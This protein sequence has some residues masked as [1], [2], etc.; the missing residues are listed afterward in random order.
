VANVG[1]LNASRMSVKAWSAGWVQPAAPLGCVWSATR[2]LKAKRCR[3]VRS[4][5]PGAEKF[6]SWTSW[7]S[8]GSPFPAENP[9]SPWR[10]TSAAPRCTT[11]PT[12][13]P[14]AKSIPVIEL[15]AGSRSIAA[16]GCWGGK[17]STGCTGVSLAATAAWQAAASK[18]GMAGG[19]QRSS[20]GPPCGL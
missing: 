13:E 16:F 9:K 2:Q 8:S 6:T 15:S 11:P 10:D 1:R 20:A 3:V 5:S 4:G 7:P 17:A 19:L 14:G 18:V 12:N